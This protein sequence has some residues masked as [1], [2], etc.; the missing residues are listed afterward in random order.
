MGVYNIQ[1]DNKLSNVD[2]HLINKCNLNCK[3]CGHFCPLVENEEPQSFENITDQLNILAKITNHGEKLQSLTLTGGEVTLRD[4]LYKIVE[5]AVN[6][7]TCEIR[8][9]S[10]GILYK[11][12]IE[13]APLLKAHSNLKLFITN[14]E[15]KFTYK[16]NEELNKVIPNL[17]FIDKEESNKIVYFN[18]QFLDK[19][20]VASENEI[21]NCVPRLNCNQL[22]NY[23]LYVCQYLAYF[24]YF[25]AKFKGQHNIPWDENLGYIDIR[26]VKDI[27]EIKDFMKNFNCDF[28]KHCIDCLSWRPSI[29]WG[30]SKRNINE[31]YK[32]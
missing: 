20:E 30:I 1:D 3:C 32:K 13:L 26:N 12:L 11:K 4:D 17:F 19:N 22:V 23:K 25:D 31:W 14:Y 9:W 7:F 29:P 16:A 8:I 24:K 21:F 6:L 18:Y 15:Q 2:F 5:F 28:C 10:N 27:Q